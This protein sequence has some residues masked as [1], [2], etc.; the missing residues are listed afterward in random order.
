MHAIFSQLS[1]LVGLAVFLTRAWQFASVDSAALTGIGSAL[2]FYVT[3]IAGDFIVRRILAHEGAA[4]HR[5]P[6]RNQRS[7][8]S[9]PRP[10]NAPR[11]E[12]MAMAEAG[13]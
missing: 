4:P 7:P 9:S 10:A 5:H 6:R 13:A 1:G 12:E 8:G 11:S 3:L 2:A